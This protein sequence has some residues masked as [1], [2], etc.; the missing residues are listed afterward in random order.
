MKLLKIVIMLLM[1]YTIFAQNSSSDTLTVESKGYGISKKEAVNDAIRNAAES[2]VGVLITSNT[3]IENY[4]MIK[5]QILTSANAYVYRYEEKQ[6]D[7]DK[8]TAMYTVLIKA[9]VAKKLLLQ[10]TNAQ[11]TKDLKLDMTAVEKMKFE[12]EQ[13][14][15]RAVSAIT[16]FGAYIQ[17]NF[18]D[19]FIL[20]IDS[21]LL[22]NKNFIKM[23]ASIK[24]NITIRL[25]NDDKFIKDYILLSKRVSE[26]T[27][28]DV[29]TIIKFQVIVKDKRNEQ[30]KD[31][32]EIMAKKLENLANFEF[33]ING[34]RVPNTIKFSSLYSKEK[35]PF[36]FVITDR[37]MDDQPIESIDN[38]SFDIRYNAQILI[39]DK[40]KDINIEGLNQ[41]R[42]NDK[43]RIE[44]FE[45]NQNINLTNIK[46]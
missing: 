10:N 45:N 34:N 8:N 31:Y 18:R 42:H 29:K 32:G 21:I 4:V 7:F 15:A 3:L 28:Q 19:V 27:N 14:K 24:A 30:D 12:M 35:L 23:T 17:K 9:Y 1:S 46:L 25:K 13:S 43:N 22:T 2:S 37:M 33:A 6:S 20:E 5:D 41:Y 39:G 44:L 40:P 36:K 11:I 26:Y 16:Y 38:Y